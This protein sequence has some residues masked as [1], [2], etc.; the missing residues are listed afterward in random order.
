MAVKHNVFAVL[1]S[2]SLFY[3]ASSKEKKCEQIKIPMCQSI[4]YNLTSM[5]NMFNHDTQEEAAL[6]IH[7]FWP[8]VEIKCSSDLKFFLCSLYAPMCQPNINTNVPPCRSIC[9]RARKGC[10]PL[11]GQYGLSWPQRMRCKNFPKGVGDEF[12]L[13]GIDFAVNHKLTARPKLTKTKT[14]I[15]KKCESIEISECQNIGYSLTSM[16]NMFNHATQAEAA[17]ALRQ[18]WPLVGIKCSPDIRLFLCSVYSPMCRPNFKEEVPPC[19]SVCERARRGCAVLMRQYG[20]SWPE[21]M[22]CENFPKDSGRLC[23]KGYSVADNH[24]KT[25]G[26]KE[27]QRRRKTSKKKC[28]KI[29]IPLCEN[30]GY[31]LTSMPNTF[32]HDTQEEA[33][34]E[35]HQ[36]W[37]LVEINCSPDLRFF[38]CSIYAPVCQPNFK[39]QV[40]PC[41]SVCERAR[42]GCAPLMR[43]YGFSWPERMRCEKFP[44]DIGDGFCLSG[45]GNVEANHTTTARTM[46]AQTKTAHMTTARPNTGQTSKKKCEQIKIPMCQNIGYNLTSIPNMFNHVTQ[47]EAALEIHQFWPLVEIKCSPY[48]KFFLCSVYAPLCQP[49][50]KEE[51]LPCRSICQQAR[52]GCR[53]LMRQYG[54][55]WPERMKCENFPKMGD[56]LCLS[57]NNSTANH[58]KT[59]P[60]TTRTT[61]E[62]RC[63]KIKIPMCQNIGYNLTSIPNKFYH[64][65]QEEAALEIHQFWPLVE[66]KCS[67]DL[68]FFLCSIYAPVCQPNFKDQ[69]PPCRSVCERARKGCAP[70]MRQYGFSWPE[71]MRCEKFPK[72]IADGFCLSGAGNVEANQTTT[73]RTMTAQTTTAHMTT[74]RPSTGQTSKK[75]CE[76]IKIPMCQN[77][78]Y[79][80]TSIPNMFNHVTQEEAALE[81]HQFWPLVEIKCSPYLK[82]FLCSVYAP[83]C[84]PNFKEE[85]LPCRSIC[86]Q[87]RKG[88]RSLMRQ[89]G[90]P[91][92]ERM[93]CENFP[94]MG[95]RLCLNGNNSTANH[96][97]TA[98]PTTR[99]TSEK[100]CEKIKIPMCQ[101]IG[102]NLTSMPNMFNHDTQEEAAVEIHQFWPLVEIKCSPDLKFF[103]C[104]L[105][106][107]MCQPNFNDEVPPC[108][109]VCERARQGCLHFML[110]YGFSWPERMNC[111]N[112]PKV[113]G[114]KLCIDTQTPSPKGLITTPTHSG[115]KCEK[116]RIPMC[117]N[118]GYNLTHMP[119]IFNHDTQEEAALEV[120]HFWRLVNQKCSPDLKYFLCSVYAPMCQ[121]NITRRVPPCR[122]LCKSARK[123][124]LPLVR[125][126]GLS[127]PK[128]M[129]CRYFPKRGSGQLCI[130]SKGIPVN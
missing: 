93:K 29:K 37:P 70:L 69:V 27:L 6:E 2:L 43:Q 28:E 112:F 117:E 64:D 46:T 61:S 22:K 71:R 55:P 15:K 31:N 121:P 97:E 18:F 1:L 24:L 79:N 53:S 110:S 103:L 128:Q 4:G 12:C 115:K 60:P 10:S 50:V 94:K 91:W 67:P 130:G 21:R 63:E 59:A 44:K 5:P 122:S 48:L 65:T 80:L 35:I 90:F 81:I 83:M 76:Q 86:Q 32:Y 51:V 17:L 118:I 38:L 113:G 8:L 72:D 98:P 75:K 109:S 104:S 129:R 47:E 11:M 87:A 99:T 92:P 41:R 26:S 57:G 14:T 88:C 54:F 58:A 45:A 74:A 119:N 33:A 126:F 16:P 111:D 124:C 114:K 66:I 78:G 127:W 77:I 3:F 123:G 13:D 105:Y 106:A 89:Y 68:R 73:A 108:W 20:L 85:V 84:Q 96:G 9:K 40:P 107:P 49:N 39:D 23:L 120:N 95:D 34:L 19:R 52:K 36:F 102:Y 100:R 116:I 7:Q 56:R 42:K 62:K 30:I 82:F 25:A 125:P 101:N